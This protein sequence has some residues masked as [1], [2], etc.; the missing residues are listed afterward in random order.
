MKKG[1]IQQRITIKDEEFKDSVIK[2]R[3]EGYDF[4]NLE[5]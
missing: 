3:N 4:V 5:N 2:L 1:I